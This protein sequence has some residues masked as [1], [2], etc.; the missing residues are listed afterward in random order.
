MSAFRR[1]RS[2]SSPSI[3]EMTPRVKLEPVGLVNTIRRSG[4]FAAAARE[5]GKV[6]SALTYSVRELEEALDVPV[7]PPL[8]PGP[9]TAA[10][11]ECCTRAGACFTRTEAVANRVQRVARGWET[12]LTIVVET[13]WCPDHCAS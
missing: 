6:P 12:Q 13:R 7:R 1:P 11:K 10:G 5:F 4:S 3:E 2:G 9:V 8:A